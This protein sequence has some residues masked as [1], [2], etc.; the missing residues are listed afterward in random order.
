MKYLRAFENKKDLPEEGDYVWLG[1]SEKEEFPEFYKELLDTHIAIITNIDYTF[2]LKKAWLNVYFIF[3]DDDPDAEKYHYSQPFDLEN[4]KYFS[5]DK[6]DV[7]LYMA[8]N[9]YN[10]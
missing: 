3:E 7:E 6:H 9:R 8:A 5:K 4:V 2:D 1:E 10:L